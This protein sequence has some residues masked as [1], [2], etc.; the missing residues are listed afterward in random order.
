MSVGRSGCQ[1]MKPKSSPAS[2]ELA[3]YSRRIQMS[4]SNS[5]PPVQRIVGHELGPWSGEKVDVLVV[6]RVDICPLPTLF[7]QL[8]QVAVNNP[9]MHRTKRLIWTHSS[10]QQ[11]LHKLSACSMREQTHGPSD[12]G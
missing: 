5:E 4:S 9:V 2:R 8:E 1:R 10:M 11:T 12:S 6:P 7:K 3:Y